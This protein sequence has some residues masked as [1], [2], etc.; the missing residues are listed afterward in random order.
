MKDAAPVVAR[1]P[2][3]VMLAV[4]NVTSGA[5]TVRLLKLCTPAPLTVAPEP[6][7]VIVLLLP[8]KVPEL[9]HEP[10]TW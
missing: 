8:V 6:V 1:F 3:S 5:A 9:I 10:A 7:K 2:V 4:E